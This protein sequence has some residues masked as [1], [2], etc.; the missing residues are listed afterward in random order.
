ME[1]TDKMD[2]S[3]VAYEEEGASCNNT[4]ETQYHDSNNDDNFKC[5]EFNTNVFYP[6]AYSKPDSREQ[7][8]QSSQSSS[9]SQTPIS[10]HVQ[11]EQQS[12]SESSFSSVDYSQPYCPS[13]G[14]FNYMEEELENNRVS[15][16][17]APTASYLDNFSAYHEY[18]NIYVSS[19]QQ[20][21]YGPSNMHY[22]Y[23]AQNTLSHAPQDYSYIQN[24]YLGESSAT[25]TQSYENE[26]DHDFGDWTENRGSESTMQEHH[27]VDH[28]GISSES[29]PS[30]GPNVSCEY[31]NTYPTY[32]VEN[33]NWL[34][35]TVNELFD[36]SRPPPR[37][38]SDTSN[39]LLNSDEEQPALV[40]EHETEPDYSQNEILSPPSTPLSNIPKLSPMEP[41]SNSGTSHQNSYLFYVP[42]R[43]SRNP[44]SGDIQMQYDY[45]PNNFVP[46]FMGNSGLESAKNTPELAMNKRHPPKTVRELLDEYRHKSY[47]SDFPAVQYSPAN[48][49]VRACYTTLMS[50]YNTPN[51][52]PIPHHSSSSPAST[53]DSSVNLCHPGN[54]ASVPTSSSN[55]PELGN[56]Y[57]QPIDGNQ[58]HGQADESGYFSPYSESSS[59]QGFAN[60]IDGVG[61]GHSSSDA[62]G[63]P[64]PQ[65]KPE[66]IEDPLT[67]A[68]TDSSILSPTQSEDA[69][70]Q[71]Q[72]TLPGIH[73]IRR[74]LVSY[75]NSEP[76]ASTDFNPACKTSGSIVRFEFYVCAKN[77]DGII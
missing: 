64:T 37:P 51:L 32:Q 10:Q 41:A 69:I 49:N 38:P 1:T 22:T 74:N 30:V 73:H 50:P 68:D 72:T 44:E 28:N 36:N 76:F 70:N 17:A 77:L 59:N 14:S 52:A 4:S 19:N 20:L 57:E 25:F 48:P 46:H 61:A 18:N 31:S 47:F 8:L 55:Y 23:C 45:P 24:S 65:S 53:L 29:W 11:P 5:D 16:P 40:I 7:Q 15:S 3:D 35:S 13:I 75:F 60:R 9:P 6:E 39:I 42:M 34:Q 67:P 63:I 56:Y 12:S 21:D 27:Q 58:S 71:F 54:M 62:G 2:S 66:S 43:V 26:Y 33:A